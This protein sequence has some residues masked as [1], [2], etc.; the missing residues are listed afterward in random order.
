[1]RLALALVT[2]WSDETDVDAWISLTGSL[3]SAEELA[4]GMTSLAHLGY[5]LAGRVAL[6]EGKDV[7]QVLQEL[8]RRLAAEDEDRAF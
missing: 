2:A 1:L 7:R 5:L 6:H 4:A 3:E 8:G